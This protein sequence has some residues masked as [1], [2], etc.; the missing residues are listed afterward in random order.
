[1]ILSPSSQSYSYGCQSTIKQHLRPLKYVCPQLLYIFDFF[2][3][4][5]Q[6]SPSFGKFTVT[7]LEGSSNTTIFILSGSNNISEWDDLNDIDGYEIVLY[8]S[9]RASK[10]FGKKNV[11]KEKSEKSYVVPYL[12]NKDND[13]TVDLPKEGEYWNNR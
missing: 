10:S 11:I 1:M 7:P 13:K 3:R 12:G 5:F 8:S 9:V 4:L 2:Y 6:Y